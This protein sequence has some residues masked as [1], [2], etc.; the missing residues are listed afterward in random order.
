MTVELQD[1]L[2]RE[3][4]RLVGLCAVMVHNSEVAEDLAQ[5]TLYEAWRH[6][7]RLRDD[8]RIVEWLSGI[9]RNVCRRWLQRQQRD[10]IH[11][12]LPPTG[13]RDD[14]MGVPAATLETLPGD[15]DLET[16]L[17]RAELAQLLDR[18]MARLPAQTRTIL[19]EHFID[20]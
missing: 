12:L 9:A 7:D 1:I 8:A 17:E 10:A 14:A 2:A 15:L 18:A 13:Q 20:E 6:R 3:R 16:E 11:A 5:E 19:Q 4:W